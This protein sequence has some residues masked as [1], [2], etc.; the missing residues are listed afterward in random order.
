[1]AVQP[2]ETVGVIVLLE[3][4]RVFQI[5]VVQVR[6]EPVK[7]LMSRVAEKVPVLFAFLIPLAEMPDLISHKVELFPRMGVHIHIKCPGLREFHII[8]SEHFLE[9]RCLAVDYFVV[10]KRQ[11]VVRIIVIRHGEGELVIAASP[12]QRID[13]EI[14]ERVVH[15]SHIPLIIEAQ[16]AVFRVFRDSRKAGGILGGKDGGGVEFFQSAVHVFEKFHCIRVDAP[17][18]RSLPVDGA[19][20]GVH[21]Q[22]VYVELCQPVVG[23]RLKEAPYFSAGV[24][25]VAASPLALSYCGMRVLVQGCAVIICQCVVIH[26]EVYRHEVKDDADAVLVAGVNECFELV[27]CPISGGRAEKAG[28]L[29]SPGLVAR[30]FCERHDLQ[31]II[32]VL[33]HVGDQDVCHLFVV[34][35][36]VRLVRGFA[37]RAEMDF[38]NVKRF[39]A[40]IR[41]LPHP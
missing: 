18:W 20:D 23:G 10:G 13:A 6:H 11:Q 27:G 38:V 9:D 31:I 28:A 39:S 2:A 36:C 19:A 41:S 34:I 32:A 29:I 26:C 33:L 35:P 24:H 17:L 37:E 5:E 15:P 22:P 14:V 30:I 7:I 8:V 25:E 3:E 4:R 21:P 16:P 40:A 12:E 1:M